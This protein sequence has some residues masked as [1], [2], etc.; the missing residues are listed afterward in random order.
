[1]SNFIIWITGK[2]GSG[3][4]S[5]ARKLKD[6]YQN[7]IILEGYN[8]FKDLN[9][10]LR[11]RMLIL[12]NISYLLSKHFIVIVPSVSPLKEIRKIIKKNS[13]VKFF[14]IF[15]SSKIIK[16]N[17]KFSKFVDS[18]YKPSDNYDLVV[19]TSLHNIEQCVRIIT[20]YVNKNIQGE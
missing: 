15:L 7:S 10:D 13:P 8:I 6:Y 16:R 2:S 1:M 14:E 3:K 20:D 11:S 9:I 17:D 18:I 19:N 12:A 4:S 5:I